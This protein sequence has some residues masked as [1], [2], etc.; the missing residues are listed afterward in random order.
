MKLIRLMKIAAD[1]FLDPTFNLRDFFD[2]NTGTPLV[3]LEVVR[4]S[5]PRMVVR[6]L[7]ETFC[8]DSTL[9][10]SEQLRQAVDILA[11][12]IRTIEDTAY[13]LNLVR[14]IIADKEESDENQGTAGHSQ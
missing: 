5:L 11:D 9:T 12:A 14:E 4:D 13:Q 7:A 1:G 6:E 10:D 8:P 3:K 2:P